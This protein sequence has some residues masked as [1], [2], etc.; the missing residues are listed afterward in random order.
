MSEGVW[1]PPRARGPLDAE[2]RI[3]GSK[4]ATNRALVLAL[5]AEEPSRI[6]G[7]L[8][9]RDTDLMIA[10]IRELGAQVEPQGD[11]IVVTPPPRLHPRSGRID[12]GL[13]GTVMR[14]IAPIAALANGDVTLDGDEAARVR[15][16]A[17]LVRALTDMGI[18]VECLGEPGF[19]PLTIHGRG[20]VRGGRVEVDASASSQFLS[21][22]LL[23]GARFDEGLE[24]HASTPVPSLPHVAMTM[25]A[26]HARG[27]EADVARV[28]VLHG[29][30]T[31]TDWR[32]HPGPIR[33][34]RI[35]IEPDLTNAGPFLAAPL[36]AGGQVRILDWPENSTQPGAHWRELMTMVGG[37]INRDDDGHLLSQAMGP[38]SGIDQT[39]S[40]YGELVPT[41]AALAA[42]AVSPSTLRGIAHLRGHETDRLAALEESL[43]RL[44]VGAQARL[45]SLVITPRPPSGA[46]LDSYGDHR[47]VMFAALIGLAVNGVSVRDVEA[48]TK[49]FPQ[50]VDLWEAVVATGAA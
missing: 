1:C 10:A 44:G 45:G 35:I 15:P 6:E 5:L 38:I 31:P 27:V 46:E 40:E 19:L 33:G 37:R 23:A 39:M 36:I 9:C 11:T 43:T 34:G 26:L 12:C 29:G 4:S 41:V 48:V 3:P 14:F 49:T 42:L 16:M 47:M 2:V 32:V 17:G 30:E 25:E 24:I 18:E 20:R 13:A 50:F 21:A 7:A 8:S 28:S 22:L